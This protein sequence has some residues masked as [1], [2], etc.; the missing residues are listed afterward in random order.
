MEQH[1][2]IVKHDFKKDWVFRKCWGSW[3]WAYVTIRSDLNF[4]DYCL[5]TYSYRYGFSTFIV[6]CLDETQL[7]F[8]ISVESSK[9]Y[10]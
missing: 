8:W 7:G 1:C 5:K 4:S 9:A 6:S 3:G 10:L 2:R